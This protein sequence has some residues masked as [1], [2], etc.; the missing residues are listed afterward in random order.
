[1]A[2]DGDSKEDKFDFSSEG[3]ALAYISLEQ[4][5]LLAMQT[6][7]EAPGDYGRRFRG[8]R[9]VFQPVEGE[10]GEDYYVVTLSFR[11]EGDFAGNP[12]QEQFFIEKEGR[13]AHRQVLSHPRGEG[14]QRLPVIPIGIGLVLVAVIAVVAVLVVGGG[15]G[16]D[17]ET[18]VTG[19]I[20]TTSPLAPAV[21]SQSET[22][23]TA[24]P[25]KSTLLPAKSTIPSPTLEI[26]QNETPKSDAKTPNLVP[27]STPTPAPSASAILDSAPLRM[28][29][30]RSVGN[31][32]QLAPVSRAHT[33][34]RVEI[35]VVSGLPDSEF[36]KLRPELWTPSSLIF[37]GDGFSGSWTGQ[38]TAALVLQ[39]EGVEDANYSYCIAIRKNRNVF[40]SSCG[41]RLGSFEF[42]DV[43]LTTKTRFSAPN[44]IQNGDVIQISI[45]LGSSLRSGGKLVPRLVYGGQTDTTSSYLELTPDPTIAGKGNCPSTASTSLAESGDL[46]SRGAF[47]LYMVSTAGNSQALNSTNTGSGDGFSLEFPVNSS[48]SSHAVLGDL[49]ANLW[50]PSSLIFCGRGFSATLP[51]PSQIQIHLQLEGIESFRIAYCV[52]LRRNGAMVANSCST[53]MSGLSG[54]VR[55]RTG[56]I[57]LEGP[58]SSTQ[59]TRDDVIEL[60]MTFTAGPNS[61]TP[62]L[63]YGGDTGQT[64]SL[65]EI[66]SD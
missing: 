63:H 50:T 34:T 41:S 55:I 43:G 61:R 3:E 36:S 23:A 6:A 42:N 1:M 10:E 4:A 48:L 57:N 26:G 27:T 17:G 18:A 52:E 9:M 65:I 29:L 62:I 30:V 7:R 39:L 64:T 11:P 33:E 25:V 38:P 16:D 5:R 14:R 24:T 28:L 21:A 40:G 59:I 15:G 31:P 2:E 66:T 56:T 19:A 47:G 60:S 20:P 35:P 22:E 49:R 44:R 13:V 54:D 32:Q 12:G 58:S 45:V 8:I 53:E 46:R 51:G 37:T